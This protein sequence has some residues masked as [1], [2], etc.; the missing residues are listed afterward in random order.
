MSFLAT[1]KLS[2][3]AAGAILVDGASAAFDDLCQER[4]WQLANSLRDFPGVSETVPGMNNLMVVFDPLATDA[5]LL[6]KEIL[7]QWRDDAVAAAPGK[8]HDVPV[9]YGGEG[10]DLAELAQAKGMTISQLVELHT[11]P[12]YSVAAVG[13]MPGFV[14]LSGLDASLAAPRRVSP[15]ARVAAGSVM[16]GGAQTGI[17]PIT[18]PSGWHILG[19][20]ALSLFDPHRERPAYFSAGD[21]IRF[22]PVEVME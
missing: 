13:A 7:R 16:I 22:V 2:N 8:S 5:A 15:R 12:L 11:R 18:A 4:I 1:P 10:S 6:E 20:T 9:R 21:R 19:H 3:E 17:M 14:Y